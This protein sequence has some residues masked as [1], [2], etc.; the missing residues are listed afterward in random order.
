M[1]T[2]NVHVLFFSLLSEK[3]ER[4]EKIKYIIFVNEDNS[5]VEKSIRELQHG[6]QRSHFNRESV[7]MGH[8]QF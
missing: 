2:H 7:V 1:H 4:G 5:W 3:I 8:Q 6:G